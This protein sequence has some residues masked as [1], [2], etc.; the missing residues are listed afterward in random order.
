MKK[1]ILIVFACLLTGL[2]L[3]SQGSQVLEG[4]T[5]HSSILNM[6]RQYSLYLPAG[7]DDNNRSYPVLYLLHGGGGDHTTWI[8]SGEVQV[9]ADKTMA[10][11]RAT[12]MIIVMPN[13]KAKIKGYY[14]YIKGGFNYEDFFF[15]ELIPHI[16]KTYRVRTKS[17]FRAVAGQ[18]MGGGG[19]IFYALHH[20]EMFSAAAPLSAV[21]E[22]WNRNDLTD[23]LQ[24]NNISGY[25]KD[26]FEAYYRS[27]SIPEIIA[28]ADT[29]ELNSLRNIRWYI[30]CGDDD[31]LYEGNCLMHITFRKAE[32][33][34]EFRVKDGAHNWS[35][36]RNEL[37]EVLSFVSM[38]FTEF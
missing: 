22:S 25:S 23:K 16:E 28:A 27:Y 29:S 6:E 36:W 21:T 35:Y 34:H 17:R 24:R 30:S 4:L 31:Y 26:Q 2:R 7:Y 9:L 18:S 12:P 1:T 37:P 33:P 38:S 20:P 14:N 3:T 32:I 19:T 10:E 15:Q 11:G 13:A 8:Q 5:F